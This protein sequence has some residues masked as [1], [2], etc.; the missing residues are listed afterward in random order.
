MRTESP[1]TRGWRASLPIHPVCELLPELP[2]NEIEELGSDIK[3]KGLRVPIV[4]YVDPQ[5]KPWLLNG[6]SR[7]DAMERAGVGFTLRPSA[8]RASKDT[9]RVWAMSFASDSRPLTLPSSS[10]GW[11]VVTMRNIDPYE[12]VIS[13]NIRRR[14]LTAEQKRDLVATLLKLDPGKSDR[15]I[16]KVVSVSLRRS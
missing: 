5:E 3:V 13:A 2:P 4:V 9:P 8:F 14:H 1:K 16:A 15:S 7:L 6:R 12:Y 11:F 10:L